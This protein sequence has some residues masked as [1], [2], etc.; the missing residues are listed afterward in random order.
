VLRDDGTVWLNLGDSYAG[1]GKG[2]WNGGCNDPKNNKTRGMKL[3][4]VGETYSLKPK[5]LIGIPWRV[6]FALQADGWY[7]RSEIIWAKKNCM[8][9]SVK[10]RPTKSHE[11]IFLLTKSPKYYYDYEAVKTPT[12]GNAHDKHARVARKRFPTDKVS[13]IRKEGYY[14]MANLRD[15]WHIS[16]KPYSG[17]HYA[18]F[19]PDLIEPCILAGCPPKVCAKCGKPWT[20]I[21]E[22]TAMGKKLS[23]RTDE[24][25]IQGLATACGGTMTSPPMSK[26]LGWRPTC[27]CNTGTKPG[28]VLDPFIGSGTTCMVTRKHGRN[29]IGLDLKLEYLNTNARKRLQYGSFIP[30]ADGVK[31]LTIGGL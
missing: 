9:E 4:N 16:T 20:R 10:D 31:Q 23:K 2:Q 22:R 19:P 8:P 29:T 21:V 11:Q 3:N 27:N 1:S 6:A 18:V 30:V 14:P 7:L 5:G 25:H 26:T 24:K 15:V 17:A 13:G 12:K 28:V